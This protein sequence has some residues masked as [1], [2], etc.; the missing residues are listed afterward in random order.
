MTPPTSSVRTASGGGRAVTWT[1]LCVVVGVLM[2]VQA[3]LNGELGTV[4]G[5]PLGAATSSFAGGL[6][7]LAIAAIGSRRRMLAAGT[8]VRV[9]REGRLRWWHVLGGIGGGFFVV[10]QSFAT[11]LLGVA[12]LTIAVVAGQTIGG[13]TVDRIGLAPAGVQQLTMAR[14]TGGVLVVLAVLISVA[15]RVGAGFE[16]WLLL[17]PVAAGLGVA[18]QQAINGRVRAA[19]DI[20]TATVGNFVVGTLALAAAFGVSLALTGSSVDWLSAPWYLYLGGAIG[21]I[22]IGVSSAAVGSIGVLRLALSLVTGQLVGSLLLDL[23]FPAP[24]TVVTAWTFVG[25]AIAFL[26]I[27]LTSVRTRR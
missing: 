26:A 2:A 23:V 12:L 22:G 16:W 21:V 17:L 10:A 25:L 14:V 13:L 11:P 6:V 7:L 20:Y 3:R 18:F 24:T 15:G 5:S 19:T 27:V 9:V 1:V 4:I 8:L